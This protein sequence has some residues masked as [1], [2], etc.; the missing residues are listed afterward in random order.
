MS[1]EADQKL[2]YK[3]IIVGDSSVGKTCIFKKLTS[4][5]FTEKNISTIGMDRRTLNFTIKGKDD[6]ELDAEV[7]LWDTAGQ[8]RFRAIT[9][10][11][12]KSSQGLLLMYDITKRE[13]FENVENWIESIKESLGKES[14]LIV[15][16]GN[17]IDLAQEDPELRKVTKEEA[18]RICKTQDILWGGECSAK[19][20]T[21]EELNDKFAF[22]TQ[23]IY[24][25]VG[26]NIFKGQMVSNGNDTTTKKKRSF[27]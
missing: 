5:I 22:F 12:Y 13:T 3:M 10:S 8:E 6:K 25:K 19:D 21:E 24:K 23:E 16:I 2:T 1:N 7:Q 26:P 18:E 14:Y 9:S 11:Y 4:G 20:F 27:C 15:L 17:K